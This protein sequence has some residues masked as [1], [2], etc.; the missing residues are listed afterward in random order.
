[1]VW[2]CKL[3]LANANQEGGGRRCIARVPTTGF[4][5][6]GSGVGGTTGSGIWFSSSGFPGDEYVPRLYK[7]C[8]NLAGARAWEGGTIGL[9][10]RQALPV[11]LVRVRVACPGRICMGL[12]ALG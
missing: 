6:L 8:F 9:T 2:Q 5:V 12:V 10:F 4:P 3:S 11:V 7:Y 1:V